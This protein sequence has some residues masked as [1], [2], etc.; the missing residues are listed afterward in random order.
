VLKGQVR[1]WLQ[2]QGHPKHAGDLSF[3]ISIFFSHFHFLV[4]QQIQF[5]QQQK[6]GMD[7]KNVMVLA[8]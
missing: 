3:A 2:N 7:K 6:M 1:G 4:Y 5:M 8:V